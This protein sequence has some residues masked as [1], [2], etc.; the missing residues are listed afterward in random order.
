MHRSHAVSYVASV[1]PLYGKHA[2]CMGHDAQVFSCMRYKYRTVHTWQRHTPMTM[3]TRT[4][5]S[6]HVS[7]GRSEHEQARIFT[8]VYTHE[9]RQDYARVGVWVTAICRDGHTAR[10][11]WRLAC[12]SRTCLPTYVG[13]CLTHVFARVFVP[14]YAHVYT[15]TRARTHTHAHTH[16]DAPYT[17]DYDYDRT[18][19]RA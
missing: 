7:T 4:H 1:H 6:V 14:V 15:H 18:H 3:F 13:A 19:G 2:S 12:F 9:H 16:V 17:N 10:L 5:M 8:Q 11:P